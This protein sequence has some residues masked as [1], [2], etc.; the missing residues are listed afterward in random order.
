ME[1]LLDIELDNKDNKDLLINDIQE[2]TID[3][4]RKLILAT[5]NKTKERD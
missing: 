1:K 5:I 2:L 3:D 4:D